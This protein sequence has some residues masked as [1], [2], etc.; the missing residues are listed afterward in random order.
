[1]SDDLDYVRA[2][3]PGYEAY[4]EEDALHDS[5]MR[6]RAF[7]G[8]RLTSAGARLGPFDGAVQKAFD[9]VLFR[10]MFT[11]QVFVK[12]FEHAALDA[13]LVNGL[14]R[15]D[16]RLVELGES[17]DALQPGTGDLLA[18][19]ERIAQQLDYRRAP[20]PIVTP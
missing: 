19:L 9:D 1:M 4:A 5:D 13:P 10:C 6:V 15:A 11:D 17:I 20:E 3:L 14:V 2:R 8:E 12:N 7:V 18:S 16:R